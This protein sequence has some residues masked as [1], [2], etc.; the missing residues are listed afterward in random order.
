[1]R[2]ARPCKKVKRSE[3]VR[4]RYTAM[5]QAML[6][7]LAA[8]QSTSLA[9]FIRARSLSQKE[10]PRITEAQAT[11]FRSLVNLSEAVDELITAGVGSHD[12]KLKRVRD[13]IQ[14]L[15]KKVV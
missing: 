4:V 12:L 3:I 1:M 6:K 9:A 11:L 2:M 10:R 7:G 15:M 13:L 8:R 14:D 5:E